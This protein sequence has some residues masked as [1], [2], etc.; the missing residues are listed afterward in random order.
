LYARPTIPQVSADSE[1]KQKIGEEL[2]SSVLESVYVNVMVNV[3]VLCRV[4][5]KLIP[6]TVKVP[7]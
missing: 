1:P 2:D 6:S 4:T 7:V 3:S 5:V